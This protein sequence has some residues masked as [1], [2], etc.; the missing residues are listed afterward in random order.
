MIKYYP[1]AT[2]NWGKFPQIT[3]PANQKPRSCHLGTQNDKILSMCCP[4]LGKSSHKLRVHPIKSLENRHLGTQND[5]ILSMCCPKLEKSFHKLWAQP[6]KS[7]E[8]R[9]L[10][11]QNDK[12]LSMCCPKLIDSRPQ[13]CKLG[14][15]AYPRPITSL[16]MVIQQHEKSLVG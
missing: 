8:N 11:T 6:I 7:L 2:P 1:C 15:G 9:H 10:G 12:I 14:G 16:K 3:G 5:K 4:K 13:I